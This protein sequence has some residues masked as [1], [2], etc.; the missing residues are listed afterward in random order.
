MSI[1][2][3]SPLVKGAMVSIDLFDP[4]PRIILFQYNPDT[5][6]RSIEPQYGEGRPFRSEAFRLKRSPIETISL[7]I[8][9]DATDK[10]DHPE[11]NPL[12]VNFG[13]LH[14]LSAL[15]IILYPTSNSVSYDAALKALGKKD[16]IPVVSQFTLFVW[17]AKR[18]VPVQL[19]RYRVTEEAHDASLNPIR[20]TVSLEMRVLTYDD[21][22]S[23]H[24]GYTI[25]LIHQKI[26]EAMAIA[27]NVSSS[28][29]SL[30][31]AGQIVANTVQTSVAS[32]AASLGAL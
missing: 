28:F 2:P 5:L 8:E 30:F 14:E 15:E 21:L 20:A 17:G 26:K 10:L 27:A 3:G 22:D 12:A 23:T 24:P 18:I 9:L 4:I 1:F 29:G 25:Y 19:T 16:I 6:T 13:V 11:Q 7:D 31:T 32:A